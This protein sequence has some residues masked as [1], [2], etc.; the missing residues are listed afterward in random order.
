MSLK[1]LEE[2]LAA[3]QQELSEQV[4]TKKVQD[5]QDA[6]KALENSISESIKLEEKYRDKAAELRGSLADDE[7][8]T[9]DKLRALR[10]KSMSEEGRQNDIR[11]QINEKIAASQEALAA[12]EGGDGAAAKEAQAYAKEAEGLA[13]KLKDV[14]DAE[15]TIMAAAELTKAAKEAEIA[16]L[17]QS[18][19]TAAEGTKGMED[20]LQNMQRQLAEMTGKEYNVVVAADISATEA[21]TESITAR[22]EQLQNAGFEIPVTV[23]EGRAAG[24]PA[25]SSGQGYERGGRF[26]G[27]GGGDNIPVW[28]EAGEWFITKARSA[29]A[30]RVLSFINFGP[31]YAVRQFVQNF[32]A[33]MP[34]IRIPNTPKIAYADG[35]PVTHSAGRGDMAQLN[36][37]VVLGGQA[38][39]MPEVIGPR[40]QMQAF[41]RAFQELSR[42]S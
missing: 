16:V 40:E 12:A 20:E 18:A 17:E 25:G 30:D 7:K 39:P 14:A 6:V 35:G 34:A 26:P 2:Q 10:Q 8:K 32:E 13:S 24:G 28:A 33:G 27:W 4:K 15:T 22:L 36:L 11:L 1:L 9:E 31:E 29:M 3:K 37:T 21:A 5:A 41:V 19:D 23:A 38:H 42:G